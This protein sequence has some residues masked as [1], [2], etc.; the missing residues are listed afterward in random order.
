MLGLLCRLV[1]PLLLIP[2]AMFSAPIF[3]SVILNKMSV[4]LNKM[5]GGKLLTAGTSKIEY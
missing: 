3:M 5:S 4:I 2:I 1:I